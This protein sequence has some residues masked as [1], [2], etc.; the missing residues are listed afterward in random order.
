MNIRTTAEIVASYHKKQK[1]GV[2]VLVD[3]EKCFDRVEYDSIHGAFHY[4]G[5]RECFIQMLFL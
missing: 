1:P 5:F 2:I 3:F 4:F